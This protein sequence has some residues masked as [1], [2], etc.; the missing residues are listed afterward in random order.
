[1]LDDV[2]ISMQKFGTPDYLVFVVM[3]VICS[4]I[5]IYF[6][7]IEKKPKKSSGEEA[8]YLVGGRQMKIV[9][10]TMS[11]IARFVS[12]F[13]PD[14]FHILDEIAEKKKTKNGNLPNE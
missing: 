12:F 7:F 10:I 3:L 6:G 5:G 1:M 2:K 8:D 9:P 13:S 11:L 14:I 4:L